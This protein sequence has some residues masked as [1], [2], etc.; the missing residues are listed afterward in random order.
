MEKMT[1]CIS[2]YNNYNYLP[3]AVKSVRENSHF[4][5]APF[6]VYAENCT[7]GTNEWLEENKDKYNLEVYIETDNNP[8]RGIGGGMDLCAS[9]VKTEFIN[10]LQ[11]DIYVAEDWDLELLKLHEKVIG[12]DRGIVFS[13]RIQPDIFNDTPRPG[14]VFVPL[15]EFGAYYHDFDEKY[16]LE[17]CKEFRK[18]NRFTVRKGE[19]VSGLI[20][21]N[22]WDYIGG[23]DDRFSPAYCEDMD[24]FIRMQNEGFKFSLTSQSL[25]Y[26]FASRSSRFPDD[27][28]T[29]RPKELSDIEQN[30]QREFI[31][32]YGKFYEHDEYGFVKPLPI[33]D[34]SPNRIKK[35]IR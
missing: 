20:R 34:G 23:N 24:L 16:F 21:K 3:L 5:D 11:A 13:H 17:Y 15:D 1:F 7:D 30:S 31:K 6:V 26:H 18:L 2:T 28:L 25:I 12:E 35:E 8:K 22:D 9:K 4:K 10:F 19:G 33:V 32:K 27:D 14:T 29:Q